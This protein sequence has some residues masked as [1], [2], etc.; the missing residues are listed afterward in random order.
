M[1]TKELI[2]I[3]YADKGVI[4]T[5]KQ[6]VAIGATDA[7]FAMFTQFCQSTGLNPFKKEVW[8]IKVQNK[9]QMMTGI[10]GFLAIANNHPQ[11]DGLEIDVEV[12]QNGNPLKA[13]C[14]VFRKDRSRPSIG[15]ALMKEFKKG[16]P[17]WNQMPSVMLTKV[18]K[19]IA[20]REAFPQ[21]LNGLYTAEEMPPE[22]SL[23]DKVKP[24][25]VIVADAIPEAQNL[26]T[27]ATQPKN[28]A[29]TGQEV[30]TGG[31]HKDSLWCELP[32]DYLEYIRHHGSKLTQVNAEKEISRREE[33]EYAVHEKINAE[34]AKSQDEFDKDPLPD[35]ITTGEK[36]D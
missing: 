7:E 18:A 12:D 11:Y 20:L 2:T 17:I 33:A 19:S 8:F 10:N 28:D 35:F 27:T 15:I 4:N 36:N 23:T 29:W 25:A 6:T 16:S 30:V 26:S 1:E 32:A 31:K 14:K 3:D 22:Y 9:V 21:E 24:G 34:A 5:L 13:I